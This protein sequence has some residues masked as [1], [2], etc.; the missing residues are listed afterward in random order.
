MKTLWT[1]AALLIVALL[2]SQSA[3]D[4]FSSLIL[5]AVVIHLFR[6]KSF[7]AARTGPFEI[8]FPLWFLI[9]AVGYIVNA[10]ASPLWQKGLGTFR[11]LIEFI[12]LIALWRILKP[13][14]KAWKFACGAFIVAGVYSLFVYALGFNPLFETVADRK[15]NLAYLWRSG[16][17][18]GEAMAWSHTI[19][20]IFALCMGATAVLARSR[21]PLWKWFATAATIMGFAVLFTMTR[22]V[23][24]AA[25]IAIPAMAFL[26]DWKRGLLATAA[27]LFA[28][29][30]VVGT[31]PNVRDRVLFTLNFQQTHDSER[32]VLWKTNW[33][34]FTQSPWVG[35]GYGENQRRLPEAYAQLGIPEGQFTGHAH[36]QYIHMLSGT[37]AL[38]FLCYLAF[39]VILIHATLR[40]Y[41]QASREQ[42]ELDRAIALGVFGA[43]VLFL[44][45]GLTEANFSIAKNR[46]TILAIA[47]LPLAAQSLPRKK[48]PAQEAR[49]PSKT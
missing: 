13:T 30:L 1:L 12:A 20:P 47:A 45:G 17:F 27:V 49:A 31:I 40:W 9:L 43:L 26:L 42:N 5:I 28:A 29:A 39:W 25:A 32:L 16:G 18:Y 22:G 10:E 24:V 11:W 15:A 34:I 2:T 19:G 36:N 14:N 46:M 41:R 8:L 7:A 23:W 6:Q 21:H 37:G 3:I 38:G 48:V 35:W 4:L 44:V 33:H